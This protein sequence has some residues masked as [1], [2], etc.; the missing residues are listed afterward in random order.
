MTGSPSIP[1]GEATMRARA[2]SL[3]PVDAVVL[4]E[5]PFPRSED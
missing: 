2:T 1:L 3:A 4:P 5:E